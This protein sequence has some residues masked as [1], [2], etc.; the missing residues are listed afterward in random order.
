MD[1][2]LA[3]QAWLKPLR[4]IPTTLWR[5]LLL[6]VALCWLT[7]ALAKLIWLIYDGVT[8]QVPQP[9][10]TATPVLMKRSVDITALIDAHV[11]GEVG[12]V[13]EEGT[14]EIAETTVALKL[15]GVYGASDESKASAIVEQP[16]GQQDVVFNG[17][18][19]PGNNGTLKQVFADR[20]VFDRGGRLETLRME[21][22][23]A[24]LAN[25]IQ[26]SSDNLVATSATVD[27][28]KD[29]Q[30]AARLAEVRQ[31]FHNDPSSIADLISIEPVSTGSGGLR[32]YRVGPGKDRK[33]FA[34]AGLQRN[35]LLR[36]VNGISL[37]D[38]QQAYGIMNELQNAGELTLTIDR[39]GQIL[40]VQLPLSQP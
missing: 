35:D 16:G 3:N 40:T 32:G 11:F 2:V 1:A 8:W 38:P 17:G 31:Q 7:W 21:D 18:A 10:P 12:V 29:A 22:A 37:D 13:K 27:H 34:R 26:T 30:L 33:L 19:M 24:Q 15:V 5:T 23:T 36:A 25:Q 6:L 28:R 9:A 39:G 20:I 14:Q 4:A